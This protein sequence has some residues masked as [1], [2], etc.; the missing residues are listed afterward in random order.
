MLS[1]FGLATDVNESTSVHGGTIAY[2]APEVMRG[3]RS[4]TA[5]DIWSLGAVIYEIVF[6]DK[7]RWSDGASPEILTPALGRKLTEEERAALDASRACTIRDP[8]KRIG[9]AAAAERMLSER[10]RWRVP[11][12]APGRRP[13]VWAGALALLAAAAVLAVGVARMRR[14]VADARAAAGRDSPVIVPTG[15]AVDWTEL[16][17]VIAETPD[18]ITCTRLLPDRRTI[19]FV[20]GTPPRAEDIDAVTRKRVASPLVP[21]AYA[22]GC[23]DLSPDGKRLDLPGTRQGRARVRVSFGAPRR[24]RR[25]PGRADCRADDVV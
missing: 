25:R 16:S 1:D 20:W 6:A 24:R 10:R 5:S 7:P 23:P 11:R 14:P 3:D 4:T 15:A 8:Q 17:T 19:R 22:E 21:A 12:F 9:S 2:M 13:L 18:R